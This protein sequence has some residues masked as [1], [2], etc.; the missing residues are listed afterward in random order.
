MGCGRFAGP[1]N[2]GEIGA[3][4]FVTQT[5]DSDLVVS[6]CANLIA[7]PLTKR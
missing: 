7:K 5:R 4:Q 1:G 3:I 2:D 6:I